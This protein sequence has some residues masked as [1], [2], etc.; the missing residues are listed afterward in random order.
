M[1]EAVFRS[2]GAKLLNYPIEVRS[3]GTHAL[4]QHPAD[5][6]AQ[7]LM[8]EINL[9]ISD[10]RG[11][12]LNPLLAQWADI[13]FVMDSDQKRHV[14][15]LYPTTRGKVFRLLEDSGK[16]IPDPYQQGIQAFR[17]SLTSIQEGVDQW[18]EK[19]S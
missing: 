9:D 11:Q 1:A 8:S 13:I 14:E 2:Q 12:K 7:H 19:L 15:S 3:A 16:D 6:N 4:I 10:H 5:P 18:I 17:D